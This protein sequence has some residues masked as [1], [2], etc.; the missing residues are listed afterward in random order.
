MKTSL[1]FFNF[2]VI[3]LGVALLFSCEKPEPE[4]EPI[5]PEPEVELSFSLEKL[6]FSAYEGSQ[7][8]T[9]TTNQ[10]DWTVTVPDTDAEWLSV[11]I[12]GS[13]VTISVREN[14][15]EQ[16]RSGKVIISAGGKK[17]EIPVNQDAAAGVPV[18]CENAKVTYTLKNGTVVAPKSFASYIKAHDAEL[19]TFTVGRDLPAEML[20]S[21]GTNLIINTPT[22]VLPGGLLACIDSVEE[23]ADGYRVS[24]H[25]I[26]FTAVF[27][28]LDLD[29]DEV[30]LGEY[31][32]RIED[33]EGNEVPFT[34]T[35]ASAQQKYHIDIPLKGWDLPAGFTLT[36]KM[37]LDIALK[38]QMIIGDF[39]ISTLNLKV[40]LDT[41][42]G[43]ELELAYEGSVSK[44]FK[45]LSIYFAAIP[46]GPV[47][48]TPA[49]DIYAVVGAD[50]K[51][52]FTASA[53]N[54]F[55]SS[56]ELHYDEI[57]GLS[58]DFNAD[59]PKFGDTRYAVGVTL[60]G[61]IS[62]GL[63]VGPSIGVYTDI[64]QAGVTVNLRQREGLSTSLD[65]LALC[66]SHSE[67]DME[68]LISSSLQNAE[69]S[70]S[71]LLDAS[72]HFRALGATKD[73]DAPSIP[74]SGESY[75]LFPALSYQDVE[76]VQEGGRY[77][78]KASL[79]GPSML[80]GY[81]GS[82][83]GEL[84]VG[85]H[86]S[87]ND[88]AASEIFPFDLTEEKAQALWD[89]RDN[90]QTIEAEI[91]GLEP[92]K[93]YWAT[94]CLKMGNNLL[95][96]IPLGRLFFLDSRTLQTIRSI[97]SEVKACAANEWEGCNWDD[98]RLPVYQ[99]K[100]IRVTG[101]HG[102]DGRGVA[103]YIILP[104]EW[105]LNQN[106]S[107]K[108]CS[109]GLTAFSWYL[110]PSS[111]EFDT[112]SIDD[113]SFQHFI[114]SGVTTALLDW[115]M[116]T[117]VYINHSPQS[118]TY[119]ETTEKLDMSGSG[120][121]SLSEYKAIPEIILDNCAQLENITLIPDVDQ[122]IKTF[123]AKNCPALETLSLNGDI[124]VSSAQI[125]DMI[126]TV[127]NAGKA[128]ALSL[129]LDAPRIFDAL[130]IGKGVSSLYIKNIGSL[131]ISNA[132]DLKG[133]SINGRAS[134]LSVS[135]CSQLEQLGADG[136]GLESFS[137]SA[138]PVL[139]HLGVANNPK[140]T[141]VVPSVFDQ[142]RKAGGTLLYDIR[143]E[144]Y[145]A[146]SND[147]DSFVDSKGD[148]WYKVNN[149]EGEYYYY[150]DKGHGFYYSD[151]PGRGYHLKY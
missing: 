3:L 24:Y 37:G 83:T 148:T 125:E 98:D 96:L 77:F 129:V 48:L 72:L 143:Y 128:L 7:Q 45:L 19:R 101:D 109:Q 20:P 23:S 118:S 114:K 147:P 16:E 107:I 81:I 25:Q 75:K 79:S 105:K 33:A 60:D 18:G 4:P 6:V 31:V 27:K 86:K 63:G 13:T 30:D 87:G 112:I 144:Y 21:P 124:N 51:I 134:G 142:I 57:N 61:G 91:S 39:K 84:V 141:M 120:I 58:G 100:H 73:F 10:T 46:M 127:A 55:H 22:K 149:N 56:A 52:S 15:G 41:T 70:L 17:I 40:D 138:T 137:I 59:P 62:Y 99:Y 85:I 94:I 42:L 113:V 32:T 133:V 9:V 135:N 36:P 132:S 130:T 140:L 2:L 110:H 11:S 71:W 92:G 90:P 44:D 119:P 65:L 145:S 1:R 139:K 54:V 68:N 69:Y 78:V 89:D 29:T 123:S 104:D 131:T 76:M 28:D 121:R 117:R 49:V 126:S 34:K 151:E 95:P 97:L 82:D 50:G 8:A 122:S 115:N 150:H 47:V 35:K 43:A 26:N 146:T 80:P 5:P 106:L 38:M 108:N 136:V 93:E 66:A 88:H 111:L 74:L 12:S 102:D 53:T 67:N 116:K 14:T 64:I 103:L